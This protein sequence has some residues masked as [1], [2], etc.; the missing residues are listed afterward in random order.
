MQVMS[1]KQYLESPRSP[2]VVRIE[3]SLLVCRSVSCRWSG[4]H[5]C[6]LTVHYPKNLPNRKEM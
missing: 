1:Q 3:G 2:S 4:V 5:A 6:E